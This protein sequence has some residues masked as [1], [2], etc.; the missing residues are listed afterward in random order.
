MKKRTNVWPLC[1]RSMSWE[2]W[3]V[4][5]TLQP[6]QNNLLLHFQYWLL[7]KPANLT[8]ANLRRLKAAFPVLAII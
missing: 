4:E 1:D 8:N 2:C 7:Y 6:S 5:L 3:G